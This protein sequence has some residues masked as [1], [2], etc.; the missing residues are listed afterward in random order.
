MQ[1]NNLQSFGFYISTIEHVSIS[2]DKRAYII[3]HLEQNVTVTFYPVS[4]I[5]IKSEQNV[6]KLLF[7]NKLVLEGNEKTKI[8]HK[9]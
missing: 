5:W 6:L 2:F 9:E 7:H 4:Q 8:N 1:E 3:N